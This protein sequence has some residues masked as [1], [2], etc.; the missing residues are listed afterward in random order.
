MICFELCPHVQIDGAALLVKTGFLHLSTTP[1]SAM[2]KE[3]YENQD[4]WQVRWLWE[5]AWTGWAVLQAIEDAA[6][7]NH[8][9]VR[10]V[11]MTAAKRKANADAD[12]FETADDPQH[13]AP[14][15]S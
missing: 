6:A 3:F 14:P 1:G 7:E 9:Q 10:I 2:D 8:T 5:R 15:G 4:Y 11:P 12:A 13:A